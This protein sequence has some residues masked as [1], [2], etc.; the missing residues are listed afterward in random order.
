MKAW[1]NFLNEVFEHHRSLF[2]FRRAF[3]YL[4]LQNMRSRS[5]LWSLT[6]KGGLNLRALMPSNNENLMW[7]EL[8]SRVHALVGG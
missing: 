2:E 7:H 5:G 3:E 4:N 8:P 1:H 6:D